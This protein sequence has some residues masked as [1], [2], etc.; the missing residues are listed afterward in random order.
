[1]RR[2]SVHTCYPIRNDNVRIHAK[3]GVSAVAPS[4]HALLT[5]TTTSLQSYRRFRWPL[6]LPRRL[7]PCGAGVLYL[8]K[9]KG[10][11]FGLVRHAIRPLA[12]GG[13]LRL[14]SVDFRTNHI[15]A[16]TSADV[17]ARCGRELA[18]WLQRNSAGRSAAIR[19]SA[20]FSSGLGPRVR[21]SWASR[22]SYRSC[23]STPNEHPNPT[24]SVS[25]LSVRHCTINPRNERSQNSS[26]Q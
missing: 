16:N 5:S 23:W 12:S 6:R 13:N 25:E 15:W 10:F 26:P 7:C 19:G 3:Q 18:R 1:M 22:I 4:G 17:A 20:P 11:P 2:E 9:A 14:A 8:E 21:V 24:A